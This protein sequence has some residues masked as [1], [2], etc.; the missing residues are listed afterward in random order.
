MTTQQKSF[1]INETIR[2]VDY[3]FYIYEWFDIET[4]FIFYV[5]KGCN[6]RYLEHTHRNKAFKKYYSQH[7]CES[8]IVEY[9]ATE[10]EAFKAENERI[11]SLKDSGECIC[12]LDN[13]GV[14]GVNFVW[15]EEMRKYK[16]EYNPMKDEKQRERMR[17]K[18]PMKN[19]DVAKRNNS[20]KRKPVI[21][22]DKRFPSLREASKKT[23]AS[24]ETIKKWC[25]LGISSN[26]ELCRF[27]NEKQIYPKAD[28][29]YFK[30]VGKEMT[31]QGKTFENVIVASKKLNISK[32]TLYRWLR[33]GFDD[34]GNK[35]RYTSDNRTLEFKPVIL[36]ESNRKP[37]YV[38]DVWYPS[39]AE[40]EKQLGLCK[41]Y[42]AAYLAGTR[43]NNKYV[44]RYDNQQPSRWK[45]DNSTTEGSTTNG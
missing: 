33:N 42:L 27:E 10:E 28:F 4:G 19:K 35:C 16:S 31:Y 43:K 7:K 14:G 40:A 9:F 8:R 37:I 26:G 30:P 36:G 32:C 12:N 18:N 22:G 25:A 15:T 21:I 20:K 3:I 34:L 39:K 5:G 23:G 17:T 45:P 24:F 11:L 41:G 29:R 38:N 1:I 44:C 2:G 6:R 13:G